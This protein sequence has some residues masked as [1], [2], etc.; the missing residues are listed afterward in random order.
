MC[1]THI[2]NVHPRALELGE[3]QVERIRARL[4]LSSCSLQ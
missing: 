4:T 3:I 1:D 2:T